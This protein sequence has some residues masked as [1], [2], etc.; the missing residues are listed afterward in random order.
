MKLKNHHINVIKMLTYT[1]S[2]KRDIAKTN[3]ISEQTL[4]NW[5][6]DEDFRKVQSMYSE[7]YEKAI[8]NYQS[9]M[10]YENLLAEL[11]LNKSDTHIINSLTHVD[12]HAPEISEKQRDRMDKLLE[13]CIELVEK[14][15]ETNEANDELIIYLMDKY[16]G[17]MSGKN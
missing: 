14:R 6:K 17:K 3:N 4:Y 10:D 5:I 1:S 9:N 13:R 2:A 15:I 7:R 11:E 16:F 8:N 12:S